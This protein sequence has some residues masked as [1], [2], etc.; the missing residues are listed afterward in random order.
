MI[1]R[2]PA[3]LSAAAVIAVLA[4]GPAQAQSATAPLDTEVVGTATTPLLAVVAPLAT[5]LDLEPSSTA[6]TALEGSVEVTSVNDILDPQGYDGN[7]TLTV[8]ESGGGDGRLG[9]IG[10][11]AGLGLPAGLCDDAAPSLAD[12][13][14]VTSTDPNGTVVGTGAVTPAIGAGLQLQ[15]ATPVTVA[16]KAAGA[17]VTTIPIGFSQAVGDEAILAG[18][19]YSASLVWT[20]TAN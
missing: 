12:E 11:A 18:C 1:R 6:T 20:A 17:A 3:T 15:S 13:L 16:T 19:A 4:A 5:T 9:L 10:E 14:T 2:I 7:W 8:A